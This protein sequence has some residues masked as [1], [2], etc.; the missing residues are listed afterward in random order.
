MIRTIFVVFLTFVMA[1]GLKPEPRGRQLAFP[2]AEG[3]GRF[4]TGGRGGDVYHVT[5]LDDS[6]NGSLRMGIETANGPRTIVFDVSGT[7]FLEKTL[8]VQKPDITIAGQ[9][10]PGDGITLG[11]HPF[12]IS[13]NNIIVRYIRCRLGDRGGA[14]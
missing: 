8:S 14:E 7:I 11:D 5:N 12:Y 6:E 1:S 4:A 13:A 10:A 9:T 2:G 3:F